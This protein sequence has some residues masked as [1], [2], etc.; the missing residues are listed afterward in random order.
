MRDYRDRH[1]GGADVALV[2]EVADSSLQFDR[3]QKGPQYAA[4]S[5][6]EYWIVNLIDRCVEVYRRPD[7]GKYP[8]PEVVKFDGAVELTLAGK[9]VGRFAVADLM[10]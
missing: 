6:P 7:H 10:P 3:C 2:V 8:A 4:A 1:P 9:H 5:I